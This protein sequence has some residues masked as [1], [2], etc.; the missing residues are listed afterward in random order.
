LTDFRVQHNIAT[1][2]MV[3]QLLS[4]Y[5]VLEQLGAGGMGV[6]YRAQDEQLERG[7]A[8][9]VL[10]SGTLADEAAR[11]RFRHEALVLAKLNH[12][13]IG[14][15]YEFGTQ[16]QVDFLVMELVSGVS[17][18]NRLAGGPLAQKEVL[19]LGL[20]LADGLVTAHEQGVIHRDLKP[21]N[22]R[23]TA[24][25]RLKILDFGL[26]QF[27]RHDSD[28]NIT[29]S[30]REGSA[31]AGTLPYMAP[32]Q[33]RGELADVRADIWAAGA[34]LYEMA[35]SRRPFPESQ[36][37]VLIHSILNMAPVLP[38]VINSKVLR[39]L[40]LVILKCL[41]K[42]PELRYQS[43][44]ELRVDLERLI[45]QGSQ[46]PLPAGQLSIGGRPRS[47]SG[48]SSS[49]NKVEIAHVL[50][51]GIAGYTTL[52]IEKQQAAL[53]EL[54]ELVSNSAESRQAEGDGQ[55]VRIEA[56]DGLG[57]VFFGDP[58]QPVRCARELSLALRNQ[59]GLSLRMGIHSGLVYRVADLNAN[60]KVSGGGVNLA[61]A[62]MDSGE[63][64]HILVSK[65]VA[66]VLTQVGSWAPALHDLG[67][68][69]IKEDVRL[70]LF[71]LYTPEIGNP[72]PPR[73]LRSAERK[74][75]AVTY[76][77]A[78]GVLVALVLIGLTYYLLRHRPPAEHG[79]ASARHRRSFAVLGIR[80]LTG[81][82]DTA[83]LATALPEMLATEL[84]AGEELRS[85]PSEDIA[86]MKVDL[87]LPDSDTLAA[88][89][90]SKVRKNIGADLV[91]IGSYI[92]LSGGNIRI[93][94]HLQ[95]VATGEILGSVRETGDEAN[96]F[97]LV[98]RAGA[99][100]R[101][102][103]G[104]G[105]VTPDQE[106]GVKAS[107]PA[108]PQATRFYAEGLAK[109]RVWDALSA[110]DLLQKAVTADPNHALAHSALA[111]CWSALGY[112]EKARQSAKNAFDLSAELSREDRLL[113]EAR[114]REASKEWDNAVGIYR[115]LF[116]FFPDNLEYGLLLA[117][118]QSRAG[119]GKDALVTIDSLRS[120]PQPE[121]ADARIDLAAADTAF[122]L[123]DFK[124][125]QT[126]ASQAAEKGKAQ[127]ARLVLARA[128]YREC[129]A[130][131]RLNRLREATAAAEAARGIYSAVGDQNGVASIAEAMAGVLADQGDLTSAVHAYQ[132]E[133][134]IVK[135]VGNRRGEASALNNL[136]LV[137]KQQGQAEEARRMWQEA[138][139]AFREIGDKNNAAMV[140][141][142]VGGVQ[143]DQGDHS[144]AK[145]TYE[146]SLALSR[147]TNDQ[148]GIASA[149]T[150]IATVLDAQGECAQARKL[151]EQAISLD[152]AGGQTSPAADKLVDLGDVLQHQGD[153]GNARR[154]YQDALTLARGSDDKS[155]AAYALVGLGSIALEAGDFT[156]SRKNYEEAIAIRKELGESDNVATTEAYLA[157]L[158]LEEGRSP[159]A[160]SEARAARDELKKS[161]KNDEELSASVIVV[162]ALAASGKLA[163]A[164]AE[165]ASVSTLARKS[166]N[167]A[168]RLDFALGKAELDTESGKP[169][170]AIGGLK[171]AQTQA[172]RAGLLRYQLEARLAT[173][174]LDVKSGKKPQA[175]ASLEQLRND[176][177]EKG[178]LLI[179][180]KAAKI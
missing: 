111:A 175:R 11:K 129:S 164:R 158:A 70:Q 81:R 80:N 77:A 100:L 167:L 29:A 105:Q 177:T 23:L 71:N 147:E 152:I 86:R 98:S 74:G 54:Q 151:L 8:I 69:E 25:G 112:D 106:T 125:S 24:D 56:E 67:E 49:S 26:A 139:P 159:A 6:V 117:R 7:V 66:D 52:S 174:T 122:F 133:L 107:L 35:T 12:P 43:A 140:L 27:V 89:T 149:L 44:R 134:S 148:S 160:E 31:V 17:L 47:S 48:V 115:T 178:F 99:K 123:G 5:R 58:E 136:A 169:A 114:Y 121:G 20:Q 9:K 124:Q 142:N 3:G 127:G 73:R 15:V 165:L 92:A 4:H 145:K 41:D 120:L 157:A 130:L 96:L 84:A 168:A 126:F 85:T 113:V 50:F 172:T 128:R 53:A 10:P 109:L 95:D 33:L 143:Q 179:A 94:L 65:P 45:S 13:N 38:S 40:E 161:Q 180:R 68:S 19:R 39:A 1:T 82:P 116:G 144:A 72:K 32:E 64:G 91:V 162:R 21:A 37:P 119:K 30:I 59:P 173:A 146:D 36:A 62:V 138:L 154:N 150:A 132:E 78:A 135:R 57:L 110:R 166:Q 102:K 16:D 75:L 93:D 87:S 55:L 118:A 141:L 101:E 79:S 51:L 34:V 108:T 104:I 131:E 137:L 2:P 60:L 153:L 63:A 155:N 28:L 163:E 61:H 42:E 46:P 171:S 83:Y 22:L 18:D 90:L 88:D 97:D 103:C 76:Q 176:A 170:D 156:E 14:A